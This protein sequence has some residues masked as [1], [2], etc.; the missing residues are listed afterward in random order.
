[1]DAWVQRLDAAPE[2]LRHL[3]DLLDPRHRDAHLLEVG[4]RAAARDDLDAELDQALRELVQ[5]GLVVDRDEGALDHT[6]TSSATTRGSS[7]CSTAWTLA[8][9]D[10][11]VSPGWTGTRS[12]AMT[13]PVSTPS[14]T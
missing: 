10:S 8:R 12:T 11:T 5:A 6:E 3:R 9:S 2:Q 13:G 14:S 1:M 4:A 7:S